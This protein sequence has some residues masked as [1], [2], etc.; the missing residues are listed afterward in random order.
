MSLATS[1]VGD[2]HNRKQE[3]VVSVQKLLESSS[4]GGNHG[5]AA[6]QDAVHVEEDAH[7]RGETQAGK[8]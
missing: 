3:V 2:E 8:G 5:A 6:D 1:C 4:S 7:L